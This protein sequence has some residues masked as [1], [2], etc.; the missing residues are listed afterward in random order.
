[1]TCGRVG[2]QLK[3]HPLFI[4]MGTVAPRPM[5]GTPHLIEVGQL[6]PGIVGTKSALGFMLSGVQN[7]G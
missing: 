2:E 5:Q 1:M 4:Q 7:K 3:T 6:P